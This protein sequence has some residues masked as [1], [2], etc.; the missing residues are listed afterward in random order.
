MIVTA[1]PLPPAEIY[2]TGDRSEGQAVK[3]IDCFSNGPGFNSQ[4][5]HG[6]SQVS[7]TQVPGAL[8]PSHSLHA[9]Q[10]QMYMK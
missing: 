1:P 8:T 7:G 10:T 4:H 9:G 2:H 6:S 5:P 3:S